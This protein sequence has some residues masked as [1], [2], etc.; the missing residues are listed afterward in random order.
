MPKSKY[1]TGLE[2]QRFNRWTVISFSHQLPVIK[3]TDYFWLCKCDCG[4][5]RAVRGRELVRGNTKSCGCWRQERT[6]KAATKHG[7][8]T[9]KDTPSPE[10]RSWNHARQRVGNPKHNKSWHRYGG[11]GI[12]MCVGFDNFDNFFRLM[13]HKP[14]PIHSIDRKDN[15]GNYSCG[16]CVECLQNKWPFNTRWATPKEQSANQ[17]RSLNAEAR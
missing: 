4:T 3:S 17:S 14:S 10:Y 12:K 5:M 8:L 11:R 16:E 6:S 7:H 9:G 13:G 2:G 1:S 15:D